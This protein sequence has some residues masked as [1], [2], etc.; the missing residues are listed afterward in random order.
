MAAA[1][2]LAVTIVVEEL[3][4]HPGAE[5]NGEQG[6]LRHCRRCTLNV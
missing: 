2:V 1:G 6:L 4:T 5:S 3:E